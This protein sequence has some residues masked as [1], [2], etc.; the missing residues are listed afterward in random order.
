[1]IRAIGSYTGAIFFAKICSIWSAN[2]Y[3]LATPATPPSGASAARQRSGLGAVGNSKGVRFAVSSN[4]QA[5]NLDVAE[6]GIKFR[7]GTA[8]S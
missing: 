7:S 1:M 2:S 8:E 5:D 4:G 6:C 3:K